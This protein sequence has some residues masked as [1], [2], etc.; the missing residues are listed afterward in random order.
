MIAIASLNGVWEGKFSESGSEL[1]GNWTQE[2]VAHP[3]NFKKA[4]RE[5]KE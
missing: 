2:G 1:E 4:K 3:L 5:K